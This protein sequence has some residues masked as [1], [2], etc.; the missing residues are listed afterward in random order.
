MHGGRL[1]SAGWTGWNERCNRP[2]AQSALTSTSTSRPRALDAA[3]KG[4]GVEE[5]CTGVWGSRAAGCCVHGRPR[6]GGK[7]SE[8]SPAALARRPTPWAAASLPCGE[9]RR[10]HTA[11]RRRAG[12]GPSPPRQTSAS[13]RRQL[14]AG[15]TC[16]RSTPAP[17]P[18]TV[19]EE[20]GMARIQ[21]APSAAVLP[22][23]SRGAGGVDGSRP[24]GAR[25][26]GSL[27][28]R[29]GT[30]LTMHSPLLS[31]PTSLYPSGRSR[32][33][34]PSPLAPGTDAAACARR[35]VQCRCQGGTARRCAMPRGS[36]AAGC[37][38]RTSGPAL[39]A[40]CAA[41]G[42]TAGMAGP[43]GAGGAREAAAW[44]CAASA[45]SIL[46]AA[47]A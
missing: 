26:S 14:R 21:Q 43:I 8:P 12:R 3:C 37:P 47:A 20:E 35:A 19:R 24:A 42:L 15:G 32:A 39:R 13:L 5:W 2:P 16:S 29:P 30:G 46:R 34:A 10:L 45:S 7:V 41:L 36:R 9:R 18:G 25:P 44:A 40:I 17:G 11:A 22:A 23:G 6:V 27:R 33:A 31:L 38:G 28:R 4:G 1:H